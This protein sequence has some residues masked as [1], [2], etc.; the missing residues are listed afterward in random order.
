MYNIYIC[1][2]YP[3]SLRPGLL[4]SNLLGSHPPLKYKTCTYWGVSLV[5]LELPPLLLFPSFSHGQAL[6]HCLGLWE[7]EVPVLLLPMEG[8]HGVLQGA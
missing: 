7:V 6:L 5:C 3:P 8:V 2:G 4:L 1:T